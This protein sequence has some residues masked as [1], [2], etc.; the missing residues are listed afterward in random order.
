MKNKLS[1]PFDEGDLFLKQFFRESPITF[2]SS[3]E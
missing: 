3:E 1:N 2:E